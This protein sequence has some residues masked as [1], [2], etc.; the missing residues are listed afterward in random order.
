MGDFVSTAKPDAWENIVKQKRDQRTKS[1]KRYLNGAIDDSQRASSATVLA[2]ADLVELRS[3]LASGKLTACEVVSSY[4]RRA[5]ESHE[6]V[7]KRTR[8]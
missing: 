7:T 4:V 3:L 6:K 8:Y 5:A 1:V 2:I